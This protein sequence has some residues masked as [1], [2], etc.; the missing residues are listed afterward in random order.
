MAVIGDRHTLAWLSLR[1]GY[2]LVRERG[3]TERP[4]KAQ[5]EHAAPLRGHSVMVR[6]LLESPPLARG[7]PLAIGCV[8]ERQLAAAGRERRRHAGV[9]SA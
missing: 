4:E 7:R 8:Q 6:D 1:H 3:P 2:V 9:E 5:V